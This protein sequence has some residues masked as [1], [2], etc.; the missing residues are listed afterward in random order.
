MGLSSI[1]IIVLTT[2]Y[3]KVQVAAT[4]I[5]GGVAMSSA[6]V[7]GP[8]VGSTGYRIPKPEHDREQRVA[9]G[10]EHER[11]CGRRRR[12]RGRAS[13]RATPG[14]PHQSRD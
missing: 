1:G 14:G 4:A 6:V 8:R 13:V 2:E 9:R 10:A 12:A 5:A 3:E 7:T 11:P